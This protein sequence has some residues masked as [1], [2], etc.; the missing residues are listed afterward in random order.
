[1]TGVD[2]GEFR[3]A[4]VLEAEELL[5]SANRQLLALDGSVRRGEPN[6]RAVRELFRAMH[7]IKGLSAMVAV[8]PVVALAHRMEAALRAA[9]RRGGGF[10]LGA[11]DLMLTGVRAIDQRV[12]AVADRREPE[13]APADLLARLE[14][15]A[16]PEPVP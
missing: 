1:M 7:T 6:V 11:V 4:F 8:E 14:R 12:Q 10:D 15:A 5:T 3:T 16:A 13:D 2:L 9:D